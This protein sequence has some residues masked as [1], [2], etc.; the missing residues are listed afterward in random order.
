MGEYEYRVW[1]RENNISVTDLFAKVYEKGF[2]GLFE[3][4]EDWL[5]ARKKLM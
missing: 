3:E 4:F 5:V 1:M 2:Y